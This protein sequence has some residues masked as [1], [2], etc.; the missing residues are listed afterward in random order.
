MRFHAN[1]IHEN[2]K[3]ISLMRDNLT[4]DNNEIEWHST[5]ILGEFHVMWCLTAGISTYMFDVSE[6]G[7][8]WKLLI[9]HTGCVII[10]DSNR[11]S[12]KLANELTN[13]SSLMTKF[14]YGYLDKI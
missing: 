2:Q 4:R 1:A 3:E 6:H 5:F 7:L 11:Q 9:G 13:D 14:H 10:W 8:V 12:G